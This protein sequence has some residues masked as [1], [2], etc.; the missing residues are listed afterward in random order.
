MSKR[1][2]RGSRASAA[3]GP[4]EARQLPMLATLFGGYLHEDFEHMHGSLEGAIASF[5][6]DASADERRALVAEIS[7][8]ARRAP[9]MSLPELQRLIG[10]D[11][12]SRWVPESLEDLRR[13][14]TAVTQLK[15]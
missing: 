12:R 9:R 11:L 1:R 5:A 2:T 14:V 13:L 6:A 3:D 15:G 4:L 7:Q 8:L 10:D